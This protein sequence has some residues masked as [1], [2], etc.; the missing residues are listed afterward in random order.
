MK[1]DRPQRSRVHRL[2]DGTLF[3]VPP[4]P[5]GFART[6]KPTLLQLGARRLARSIRDHWR[7]L[8]ERG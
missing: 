2:S 5:P 8:K 7:A 3:V 4:E 6:E 1:A